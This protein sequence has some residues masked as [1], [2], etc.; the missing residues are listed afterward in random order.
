MRSGLIVVSVL[1][2]GVKQFCRGCNF[3]SLLLFRRSTN[4]FIILQWCLLLLRCKHCYLKKMANEHANCVGLS[5]SLFSSAFQRRNRV[6]ENRGAVVQRMP[7]IFIQDSVANTTEL[8]TDRRTQLVQLTRTG[9]HS[10]TCANCNTPL[11]FG[12]P[13]SCTLHTYA[14]V[15]LNDTT[16]GL[17]PTFYQLSSKIA[18]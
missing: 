10:D 11:H 9:T 17:T 4:R 8:N 13:N 3:K 2:D 16:T 15:Q 5:R 7:E 6:T 1:I 18:S 12:T 14:L